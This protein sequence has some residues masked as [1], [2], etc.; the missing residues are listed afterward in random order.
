MRKEAWILLGFTAIG[1]VMFTAC[2]N[3]SNPTASNNATAIPVAPSGSTMTVTQVLAANCGD[4]E[5]AAD[6]TW[7]NAQVVTIAFAGNAITPSSSSV[8]VSGSVATITTSGTYGVSGSLSDGQLVV[9]AADNGTVRLILNGVTMHSSTGAPLAV[10]KAA[11]VVLVLADNTQNTITD[12]AAYVLPSGETEPNAAVYSKADLTIYGNG[13]LSVTGNYNDGIASKDG[14]IIKSGTVTVN[15]VDDG[16]RGKDYVVVKNGTL[17]ITSGGDGLKSDNGDDATAGYISVES[18]SLTIVSA[19]DAIGAQTDAVVAGGTLN[20]TSGGGSSKTVS[21]STSAKGIKGPVCVVIGDGVFTISSAD[22]A[23]HSNGTVVVNGGTFAMSTGDDGIHADSLLGIN[24]G[25]MT[26]SKCYEGIEAIALAI[27]DGTIRI[28]A[29]DDGVNG[30]GGNDGSGGGGW[31]GGA[32][33]TAGNRSLIMNGGYIAVTASGD[34]VDVNGSITMTGGTVLVHGPTANDN[35]PLD[36]DGT[37][38]MTGGTVI[39][40]GSSGMAQ[41]PSSSSTQCA[42]LVTFTSTKTAGT[43]FRIQTADGSN[44]V[45]F[46]PVKQYQSVAVCCAALVKGSTYDVYVGGTS[47]GTSTDGLYSGGTYSGGTKLSSFTISGTV[48]SVRM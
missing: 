11:K 9:N 27:S 21:G 25:D 32:P 24:G 29:S 39:A 6:Y 12:A 42:V 23:I 43:L 13:S 47:T 8:T 34:G 33:A 10:T 48:T 19:G 46:K 4:H 2:H 35:G 18:G 16:I 3:D 38:V 28:N 26:I 37:F 31:P 5:L 17:K 15:A 7:D 14:L 40:A 45:T 22:D 41:A 36:Y 20:L 44:V 30:A 1:L